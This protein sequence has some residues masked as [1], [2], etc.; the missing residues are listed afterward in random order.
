MLI[1]SGSRGVFTILMLSSA[2]ACAQGNQSGADENTVRRPWAIG[3]AAQVDDESNDSWLATFNWSVAERTSILLATGRSRSPSD[4]ADVST[5]TTSVGLDHSVGLIGLTFEA[6][7]WGDSGV[8]ESSDF[9][10][11]LYVSRDRFRVALELTRRDIDIDFQ[12]LGLFDRPVTRTV[13][14]TGDGVGLS[15][16]AQLAERWQLYLARTEY[17]Y[18][19]NLAL[20]PRAQELNLLTTSALTMANSFMDYVALLGIEW[21][22][23][24]RLINLNFTRDR[25]AVDGTE[26]ETVNLAFLFPVSLRMDLEFNIGTG[27]SDLL[28]TGLYGGILLLIYGG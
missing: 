21:Q 24:N 18:S 22:A 10:S 13:S 11:S 4:R 27:N 2:L 14:L 6:E 19:R 23:G 1:F 7:Q 17:D 20:L 3:L 28:E 15:L 25:S 5:Q 12:T 16:R 8:V 9:A 26:L